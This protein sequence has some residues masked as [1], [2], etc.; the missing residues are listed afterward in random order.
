MVVCKLDDQNQVELVL[1]LE[2]VYFVWDVD[3]DLSLR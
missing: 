2:L 1:E 3:F